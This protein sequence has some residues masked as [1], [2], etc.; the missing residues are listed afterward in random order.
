ME[1][2]HSPSHSLRP[3]GSLVVGAFATKYGVE[4][5]S[6]ERSEGGGLYIDIP[7]TALNQIS[8]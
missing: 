4:L 8:R 1:E 2:L 3:K 5:R 7:A 6:T